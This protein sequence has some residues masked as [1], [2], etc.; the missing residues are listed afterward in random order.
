MTPVGTGRATG[1]SEKETLTGRA[2]YVFT[3]NAAELFDD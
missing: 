2:E 3:G 1:S